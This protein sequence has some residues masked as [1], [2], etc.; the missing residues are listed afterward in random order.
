MDSIN[1]NRISPQVSIVVNYKTIDAVQILC[2][3]S[4]VFASVLNQ[5]EQRLVQF[6]K[7]AT[8]AQ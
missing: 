3:T 2:H 1:G 6:G 4:A 8:S 5:I 7:I